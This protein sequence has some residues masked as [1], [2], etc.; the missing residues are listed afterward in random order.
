M[1]NVR[2]INH[3]GVERNSEGDEYSL[4][5]KA[6]QQ[7]IERAIRDDEAYYQSTGINR[8]SD[9]IPRDVVVSCTVSRI[10]VVKAGTFSTE[11]NHV[12]EFCPEVYQAYM[13]REVRKEQKNKQI[14]IEEYQE[15]LQESKD[16]FL[17]SM[18]VLS[19]EI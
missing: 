12:K 14:A 19:L 16:N 13:E 17:N 6:Q 15:L 7:D 8:L 3:L 1:A 5:T 9:P 11:E 4:L 18:L 2:P 10:D